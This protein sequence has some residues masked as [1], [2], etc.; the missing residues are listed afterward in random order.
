MKPV[1][2]KKAARP[3]PELLTLKAELLEAQGP[4]PGPGAGGVLRLPDQR[5]EGPVQL[6]DPRHQGA[7]SRGG[8]GRRAG[9]GVHMDLSQKII[10]AILAGFF[11]VALIRVFS[12]PFRLALK[13]LLNTLLGFLALGAVRLTAGL[14]G[15]ALGL[16]LWNA[17]VIA[18]LGLPGFVL[19]LLVQ[20][21]L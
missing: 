8:G 1:F 4:G 20:W 19:L 2:A 9:G 13:L 5:R 18:V 21:I 6:S 16:N 12:S 17:L 7:E 15:I 11:L 10:A 3:D 14:T